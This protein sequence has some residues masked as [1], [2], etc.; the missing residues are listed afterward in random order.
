[1]SYVVDR[2][3]LGNVF[4]RVLRFSPVNIIPPLPLALLHLHGARTRR[5]NGR[6]L[7]TFRKSSTLF[8]NYGAFVREGLTCTSES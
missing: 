1:M 4:L 8:E 5:T 3:A 7:G 2:V 6:S